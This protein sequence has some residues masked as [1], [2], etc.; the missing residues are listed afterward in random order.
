MNIRII[1]NFLDLQTF[2][3]IQSLLTGAW[4]PWFFN[5]KIV[6]ENETPNPIVNDIDI[7]DFQFTH[8]F[9][10]ENDESV[11]F[12]HIKPLFDKIDPKKLLRVK[13]NLLT[14]AL[15][16]IQTPFHTDLEDTT[17]VKTAIFYVN[18]NNGFT[19]FEDGT[20]ISSIE[21][22]LIIFD[23][24]ILHAGTNCTNQK[25]RCVININ[26]IEK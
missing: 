13:A 22:R 6:G 5:D 1:D 4:F 17:G 8:T 26:F 2:E 12:K 25:N 16:Q 23:G 15:E 3:N 19:V 14:P 21:N 9:F 7:F 20:R 24:N 11:S 18:T 10:Q